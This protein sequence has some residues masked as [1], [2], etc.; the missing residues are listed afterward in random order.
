MSDFKNTKL[1]INLNDENTK[2][3]LFC[4]DYNLGIHND[5]IEK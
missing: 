5:F 2:E 3:N 4:K 1:V